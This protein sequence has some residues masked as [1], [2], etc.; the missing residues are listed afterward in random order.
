L[1]TKDAAELWLTEP[2][3]PFNVKFTLEIGA[4]ADAVNVI[5]CCAPDAKLNCVGEALTPD[6]NPLMLRLTE[7]AVPLTLTVMLPDEPGVSATIAG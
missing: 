1:T 4:D 5:A 3:V 6:G 2:T 7:A